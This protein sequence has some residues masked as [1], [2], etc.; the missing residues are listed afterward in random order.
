MKLKYHISLLLIVITVIS[1]SSE[2]NLITD[3]IKPVNLISGE[4]DSI[5]ISD[6]FYAEDYDVNFVKND[7]VKINFDRSSGYIHFIPDLS[8]S[9]M[10]FIDFQY[11]GESYSI[12]IKS[13]VQQKY[14]FSYKPKKDY[15]IL[16]LFGSFNGWDRSNLPMKDVN[17]DGMYEI[18]IPLEP[19][20]YQYKFFG[21]GEEIVDPLNANKVPNGF[22]DFNSVYV[23][24][25]PKTNNQ[26]LHI[27][28]YELQN[29]KI[30]FNFYYEN[31]SS[32][33]PLINENVFVLIDNKKIPKDNIS[34]KG[35]K[36]SISFNQENLENKKLLRVTVSQSGNISNTQY[37]NI[38]DGIPIKDENNFIWND[39]IIYS[40]MIDRFSDGDKSL[41]KPILK[42]SLFEK[43]NYMGGDFQGIINKLNE[44]YFD[45]LGINTIW[46]SP[47]YDNPD[48]AYRESPIPHRWYS[49]YHGY[50]PVNSFGVEE[51]FGTLEKLKEL[52]NIAHKHQIKILID[53]VANHVHENHPLVKE[54]P[55]WF[56]QLKLSDGRLNLRLWDEYRLTTWFEPYLPK[57]NY[58]KSQEAIDFMTTNAIWWLNETGADGFRQDAVKHMPNEF[59]RALTS[60]IKREIEIP[61]RKSV[62]QIGETFGSYELINSYVNNGQL[63]AQFNFNLYDVALPTFLDSKLSFSALDS[64]MKK[65]FLVYG[66]N[67]V[68]GNIMDSHDKNRFMAFA[69]GDLELSQWSAIEVGWNNP[70]QVDNPENY[71]KAILYYAYMNSIPGIPVI[72][73]GSEFGMSGASDPDNRR[74]MRFGNDLS[75]H[76]KKM[77][78]DVKKIINTRKNNSSL[79]KGDFLTLKA[80]ENIYAYIRS[81]LNE[82]I[83]VIL[84]KSQNEKQVDLKIP[85]MYDIKAAVDLIVGEKI[86]VENNRVQLKIKESGYRFLK[87]ENK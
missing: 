34:V 13:R 82:R 20:R 73:Y 84:N 69:D 3:I 8:F 26:F 36:I 22:G 11:L 48:E 17:G 47:V 44:G 54:K 80:D 9:G 18:E 86:N 59:W 46:L 6:L 70:P 39:A 25:Q 58:V 29:E 66:E 32:A 75:I 76:E 60:R 16:N 33:G 43:A 14:K 50:W 5:L 45:S 63:S 64:E 38:F 85:K 77:L 83:L 67:H 2:Q 19:G 74:M 87:L 27:L 35:S 57:F 23:V 71:K 56:G 40:I 81:D 37:V 4:T 55:E 28:D 78:S 68:M 72:Y 24:E 12:P 41:N 1:C 7:Y 62:Y 53:I 49:G 30:L 15:K 52:I 61:Q 79:R 51:K 10:I 31:E 21:D 65:S 42:D